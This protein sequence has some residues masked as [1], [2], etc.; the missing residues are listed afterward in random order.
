MLLSALAS[1]QPPTITE[2]P[3]DMSVVR[4]EPVTLTCRANGKP[5]PIIRWFKDGEPVLTAT[6]DPRSH[7]MLLPDG[8]LFFLKAVHSRREQDAGTYWCTAENEEGVARSRN[9]TLKVACELN[10]Y[11]LTAFKSHSKSVC[12]AMDCC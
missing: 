2:H 5:T 12:L 9:A 10:H 3:L 7:R 8:A 1:A 6:E 11:S 4:N